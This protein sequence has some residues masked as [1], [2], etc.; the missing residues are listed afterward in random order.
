M[1]ILKRGLV[2]VLMFGLAGSA[3]LLAA[4]DIKMRFLEGSRKGA[5]SGPTAVTSSYEK[6]DLLARRPL[7]YSL[8]TE[9]RQIKKVFNI[10][11]VK[12]IT[13]ADLKWPAEGDRIYHL[14]RFEG[15]EYMI[16]VTPSSEG[17]ASKFRVEVYE[18]GMADKGQTNLLDTEFQLPANET[19]VFGFEDTRHTAYFLYLTWP[20]GGIAGGVEGGVLGGV[21]GGIEGGVKGGVE[22]GVSGGVEGG[23]SGG[24][25]GALV[26]SPASP[27]P[28]PLKR[29]LPVYPEIARQAQVEGVVILETGVDEAGAV[30]RVK[31]VHSIPLLDQAAVDAVRQW[32][33]AP[34]LIKGKPRPFTATV[35]VKF[36]LEEKGQKGA[37]TAETRPAA[38]TRKA[39]AGGAVRASGE[40]HPPK[41]LKIVEPVYPEIARQSKVEGVVICEATTNAVGHVVE[42]RILRSVPLLDQAAI[43]AVKQWVYEPM[44]ID[45]KPTGVVFTVT[46]KFTLDKNKKK[47]QVAAI[48]IEDEE[49]GKG[50]VKCEGRIEPPKLVKEVL[51]VY[52]EAARQA[53]V[54]GL[55]ILG[56]RTDVKG[57][58]KAARILRSVPDLDQAALA[59][60]KQWEY[61]PLVVNGKA[62]E[63]VFTVTVRFKLKEK[64]KS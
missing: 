41:L 40:V 15:K 39:P 44:K 28:Q 6:F 51:P 30:T 53:K 26:R 18:Q 52:P 14:I 64:G 8:E 33:F 37:V 11:D 47:G 43:D 62:V 9:I 20:T 34:L 24:A 12:L 31:V 63:A 16:L 36:R 35:T 57:K 58:V 5:A 46:V 3:V 19:V 50:A 48:N 10:T 54:E 25:E 42:A 22:G 4:P 29:V 23:V 27:V 60:V 45:G 21:Q 32:L 59:T 7:N 13:E 38:P 17:P 49:F 56:V 1:N 61:E 2:V 55:V